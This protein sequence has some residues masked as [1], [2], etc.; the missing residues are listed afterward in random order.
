MSRMIIDSHN[1][2]IN[3]R[4][5]VWGWGPHYTVEELL[6][7][8]D[9]DY[10]V[11]GETRHIDKAVCMGSLGRTAVGD[12]DMKKAHEYVLEGVKK[13]KDRLYFNPVFNPR[14]WTQ[15]E[16]DQ[17]DEWVEE[18]N[19]CMLKI[20]PTMHNYLLPMKNPYPGDVTRKLVHP[21]FEKARQLGVPIMIH[22]GEPPHSNPASVDWIAQE[23]PDV[24][25]IIAHSGANNEI[26]YALA[27][28]VVAKHNDN[29]YL[30]SSWVQPLDLCEMY[31]SVGPKRIIFE[32]DCAPQS[33]GHQLRQVVNLHLPPPLGTGATKDDIY[34]MI[35]GNIAR[36]C[37]IPVEEPAAAR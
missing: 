6:E 15:E 4:E 28:L 21:V 26:S 23:F 1:H 7:T 12:M 36:L 14:S 11:M 3:H 5:P 8:M 24:P 34:D 29:V 19:V 13:Y 35:G 2:V 30:G 31:Y 32:S 18:Y 10:D 27:A 25:I 37:N 22:M 17:V 33:I 9:L 16:L 20:H